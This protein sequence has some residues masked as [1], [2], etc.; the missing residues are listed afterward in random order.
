MRKRIKFYAKLAKKNRKDRKLTLVDLEQKIGYSKSI[1]SEWERGLKVPKL[2]QIKLLAESYHIPLND[3]CDFEEFKNIDSPSFDSNDLTNLFNNNSISSLSN[4]SKLTENLN[5][6]INYLFNINIIF[7]IKNTHNRYLCCSNDFLKNVKIKKVNN[8]TDFDLFKNNEA[9]KN[10]EQDKFLIKERTHLFD[11]EGYIIGSSENKIGLYN[12]VPLFNSNNEFIGL[13]CTIK[14]ITVQKELEDIKNA[15]AFSTNE[16]NGLVVEQVYPIHKYYFMS[17]AAINNFGGYNE[18]VPANMWKWLEYVNRDYLELK[19]ILGRHIP[20]AFPYRYCV[21]EPDGSAKWIEQTIHL[22]RL[23]NGSIIRTGY[24][25]D[26]TPMMKY[27]E[28]KE[29]T[30]LMEKTLKKYLINFR[31]TSLVKDVE[32][33]HKP[34]LKEKVKKIKANK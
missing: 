6:I 17:R 2:D 8:K 23:S 9:K 21:D 7:Y 10:Y 11:Q 22:K 20:I 3:I 32:E 30:K 19:I 34:F 27:K 12:K 26:I 24:Q 5:V 13:L 14:D 15:I 4:L 31:K 28:Q 29:I 25:W 18:K 33:Y 1:I 16:I